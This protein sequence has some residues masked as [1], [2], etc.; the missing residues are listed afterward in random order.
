VFLQLVCSIHVY[1]QDILMNGLESLDAGLTVSISSPV[2][3]LII[4][5]V[6]IVTLNKYLLQIISTVH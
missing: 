2:M 3:G 1:N 5:I 4:C 6:R